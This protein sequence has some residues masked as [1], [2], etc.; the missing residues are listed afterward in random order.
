MIYFINLL[1]FFNP[2]SDEPTILIYRYLQGYIT[3]KTPDK[4]VFFNN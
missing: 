3:I 2:P 4:S 1:F